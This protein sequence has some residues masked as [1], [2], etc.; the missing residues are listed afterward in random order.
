MPMR[1]E[2]RRGTGKAAPAPKQEPGAQPPPER[3][4]LVDLLRRSKY[5]FADAFITA[6]AKPSPG[7]AD[8]TSTIEDARMFARRNLIAR[9]EHGEAVDDPEVVRWMLIAKHGAPAMAED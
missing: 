6:R 5:E 8:G 4:D 7:K 1:R 3:G 2:V 9:R